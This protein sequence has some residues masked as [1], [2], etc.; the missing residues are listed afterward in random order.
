MRI[1][2]ELAYSTA[3]L[4]AR[5]PVT[6]VALDE[7]NFAAPVEIGSLL[8]LD[9][10]VT[11][12]PMEGEHRSFSCSVEAAT[13]DLHTGAKLIT[14]CVLYPFSPSL[15]LAMSSCSKPY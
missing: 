12:S 7:L 2:Y 9:S 15:A 14:K 5:G 8:T 4:F 1:S 10:K 3:C 11:F 13:I 6:F